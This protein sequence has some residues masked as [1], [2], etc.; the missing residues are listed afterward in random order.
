MAAAPITAHRCMNS[1]I[2]VCRRFASRDCASAKRLCCAMAVYGVR[3]GTEISRAGGARSGLSDSRV[4]VEARLS[5][6][7]G[8]D[9]RRV[10]RRQRWRCSPLCAHFYERVDRARSGADAEFVAQ[11]D[12]DLCV[13][14]AALPQRANEFVIRLEFAWR[15]SLFSA[16]EKVCDFYVGAHTDGAASTFDGIRALWGRVRHDSSMCGASRR[17]AADWLESVRTAFEAVRV[18]LTTQ[19]GVRH[20]ASRLITAPRAALQQRCGS[21]A[22]PGARPG[23]RR[24][25]ASG[26]SRAKWSDVG[27][28]RRARAVGPPRRSRGGRNAPGGRSGLA[29][30]VKAREPS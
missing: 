11:C 12:R 8:S 4:E 14:P 24:A 30:G 17:I 29:P 6:R 10:R 25:S 3:A 28:E 16:R 19:F 21:G 26:G 15:R 22:A 13:C 9:E 1:G 7:R 18:D 2:I 5:R 27:V 23:A 20:I